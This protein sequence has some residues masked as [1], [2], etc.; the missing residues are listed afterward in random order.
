MGK[1]LYGLRLRAARNREDEFLG[2]LTEY[3]PYGWEE[4]EFS[5]GDILARVYAE[6]SDYLKPLAKA[7]AEAHF[8][9][10]KEETDAA[11]P[12]SAWKEFFT[13]V[14]C[15]NRFVILPP[16]LAEKPFDNLTKVIIEPKS[17]FGTG[18]HASTVLCL[19]ALAML[20]DQN[21]LKPGDT[22]LDLGCGSGVL[23]IAATL[24]GLRGVACDIDPL[25]IDNARE[26]SSLNKAESMKLIQGSLEAVD[27]ARYNLIMANILAKPLI[28]MAGA[29]TK[30]IKPGGSLILS[31]ILTSQAEKVASA[32]MQTGLNEPH[33]IRK[34]E[35]SALVWS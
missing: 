13:P 24:S 29:I 9:A 35:W 7:C 19:E 26:N 28:E 16:W 2:L 31:G 3:A 4:G 5:N 10:E 8:E 33:E 11:D 6:N 23:G 15:G 30:Q 27:N 12:L 14:I 1:K 32:Y 21:K 17:A 20:Y 18:H 22:F 25:A 34:E